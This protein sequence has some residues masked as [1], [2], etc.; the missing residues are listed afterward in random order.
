MSKDKV[1]DSLTGIEDE[2]IQTVEALRSK[3]RRP[4]WIKW[5]AIAACLCLV[6][7]IAIP[8]LHHKGG[9]E[10]QDPVHAIAALEYNGKFY[11]A[12]DIPE[13]L[14]KYGLPSK[15][16]A[17]MAGEHLSYLKSDGG[18]G[19]E[20]TASQTDIEL[21]Q[22]APSVCDGVY[23]LRD[24]D[25]WYAALFCNFYQFDR[26]TSVALTELY[27]VYGIEG[28]N[29]IASITEVDWDRKK[30]VGTL[31][32]DRQEITEFY[33]MTVALWSYGNDDFQKQMF[34]G[35]PDEESQQKAHIAFADDYRSLRIETADGLRFFIGFHPNFNWIDGGGTMS[36]FKIDD[37]MHD[38]INRNLNN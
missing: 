13:V 15:I 22:Y 29:D 10:S 35:Y 4:V 28:A 30:E 33:D 24:G 16:T 2:M 32:T 14:E 31:V 1:I 36:Y 5:G 38:W 26:N 18:V 25:T 27:R 20:C 11:E 9:P 7:S 37:Q 3:K 8:V 19:Y 23:V 6:V 34:G 12:V 17:D 21:Y